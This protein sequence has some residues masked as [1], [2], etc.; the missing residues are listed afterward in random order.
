MARIVSHVHR[1]HWHPQRHDCTSVSTASSA[2]TTPAT[3]YTRTDLRLRLQGNRFRSHAR[4]P[5]RILL[6][7]P[8]KLTR[9]VRLLLL[10]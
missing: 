7:Q 10:R 9:K 6:A 5:V 3:S 2:V 4:N 1:A 8:V